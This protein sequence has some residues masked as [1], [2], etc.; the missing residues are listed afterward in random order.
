MESDTEAPN[1]HADG[2]LVD[3]NHQSK[4]MTPYYSKLPKPETYKQ[5]V[6]GSSQN[7]AGNSDNPSSEE[8][9]S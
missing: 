7:L 5:G 2:S 6:K 9:K 4:S 3:Q 1:D 8:N